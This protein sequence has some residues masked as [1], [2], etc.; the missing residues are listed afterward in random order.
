MSVSTKQ[1]H[2]RKWLPK[3]QE[4]AS[5]W[6]PDHAGPLILDLQPPE[7]QEAN[8]CLWRYSVYGIF[9]VIQLFSHVWLFETPWTAAHQA[10]LPFTVSQSLLKLIFIELLVLYNHI[11]LCCSFPFCPQSFP[12]SGSFPTS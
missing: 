6:E 11:I 12:A 10:S 1:E 4:E 9:V 3:I 5:Q 7:L 8:A 2:S